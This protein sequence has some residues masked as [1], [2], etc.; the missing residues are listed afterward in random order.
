M[1]WISQFICDVFGVILME[2]EKF[3]ILIVDDSRFNLEVLSRI[4][5][6]AAAETNDPDYPQ[7]II[8]TASSGP[9]AL[10]KVISEKPDLVLLDII[11]PG[12]SGFDV[13]AEF[14]KNEETRGV[15]VIIISGLADE[16]D[17]EKGLLLGAV[18]YITKPFKN[19][20]VIARVKTHL[21][22]VEQMRI[23]ERLSII[24][25]L[26][27]IPNRRYFDNR[28]NSEWKR[29]IREKADISILMID[30]DH[31]KKF[32]D[33]YGHQ[34]GDVVLKEVA[35]TV[36]S[37]LKR[38]TD[39][40][41]RW[42]GEEFVVLLINTEISGAVTV[43]EQIRE[44]IQNLQVLNIADAD[45]PLHVTVSIGASSIAP[46]ITNLIEDTVGA[47]DKALYDAKE[48]GR[49]RVCSELL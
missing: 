32:N 8:A 33:T 36:K 19:S 48:S 47:A 21:K 31:F 30:V 22:I 35:S 44:N 20:I 24:D 6:A 17:E 5:L 40:V 14:K 28:I 1:K 29:A 34:Q 23:I 39:I 42:G 15:P 46:S 13:L 11:M 12:M 37:T 49:N 4:L 45:T 10:E 3:K 7:Y 27:N 41:A 18:D 16:N 38:P 26:T 9:E 43:A 2:L 25:Q